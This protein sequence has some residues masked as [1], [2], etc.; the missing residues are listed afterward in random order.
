M[1]KPKTIQGTAVDTYMPV[2]QGKDVELPLNWHTRGTLSLLVI[3]DGALSEDDFKV[4][5]VASL[6]HAYR[7]V[8]LKIPFKRNQYGNICGYDDSIEPYEHHVEGN[9]KHAAWLK[10]QSWLIWELVKRKV[11]PADV[12][13]WMP[14]RSKLYRELTAKGLLDY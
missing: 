9:P 2:I 13:K 12:H 8:R 3:R 11:L 10:E 5:Q 1:A 6:Y 7:F 4:Y 14:L